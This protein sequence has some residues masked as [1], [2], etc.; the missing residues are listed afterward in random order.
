MAVPGAG[1]RAVVTAAAVTV[2][3]GLVLAGV[4]VLLGAAGAVAIAMLFAA[5]ALWIRLDR[6]TWRRYFALLDVPAGP[7]AE[8]SCAS[9]SVCSTKSNDGIATGSPDGSRPAPRAGSYLTTDR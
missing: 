5:A 7:A 2:A 1:S 3:G 6:G 4:V 9:G 8:R